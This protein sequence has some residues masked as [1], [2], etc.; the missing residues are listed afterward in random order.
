MNLK[1]LQFAGVLSL[2][3]LGLIACESDNTET[4]TATETTPPAATAESSNEAGFTRDQIK[5]VG[6]STVYPFSSA[7]AEEFGALSDH[8]TPVVE[9]TGSGGGMKLFCAGIGSDTPDITNASRRMKTKEFDLCNENGVTDITEAKI[10][11]DGIVFAEKKGASPFQITRKQLLMAVAK[12]VPNAAGTALIDNPYTNWNQIDAALPNRPILIF[13]P[14]TSSGTRDAFE[15]LVMQKLTKKMDLYKA[16]KKKYSD[17]REDGLYVPSGENDNLIVQRLERDPNAFG[18][19]GYSFLEENRNKLQG[20][21][22]DG[23][24]AVP[25]TISDGSYPVSRS[26]FFYVKNAHRGSVAGLDEYVNLFMRDTM[27][28]PNGKMKRIGLIALPTAERNMIQSN[29]KSHV[30]L[31]KEAIAKK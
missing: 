17:I 18:I 30:K 24:E 28:G 2:S 12:Q 22:V 10:G 8:P 16:V 31:T 1:H 3:A 25:A 15:E 14:P 27:I 26:L 20:S 9:S 5:I 6:S 29:V 4:N 11:F 23:V 21:L 13:G 19:F 7:A